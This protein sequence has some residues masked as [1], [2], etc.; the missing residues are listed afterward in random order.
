M[1]LK[2]VLP[3]N[4]QVQPRSGTPGESRICSGICSNLLS[5]QGTGARTPGMRYYNA[6]GEEDRPHGEAYYGTAATLFCDRI[7]YEIYPDPKPAAQQVNFH[8]M[9]GAV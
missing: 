6:R 8:E 9:G 4:R 3:N 2:Q 5:G 1:W 7:G